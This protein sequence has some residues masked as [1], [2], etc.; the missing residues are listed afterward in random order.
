MD[1]ILFKAVP[2]TSSQVFISCLSGGFSQMITSFTCKE[3]PSKLKLSLI[4]DN[5][6]SGGAAVSSFIYR[7]YA[8]IVT[9]T[10]LEG[11]TESLSRGVHLFWNNDEDVESRPA[12]NVICLFCSGK[13][14]AK[15]TERCHL[16]SWGR[17]GLLLYVNLNLPFHSPHSMRRS[18]S[19][20]NS[21][22]P[23]LDV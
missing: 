7:L 17:P 2:P 19:L 14:A 3:K 22:S 5:R 9:A 23:C 13:V 15:V 10:G 20:C 1:G 21:F 6:A 12:K 18:C 4:S 11:S 16:P 8:F